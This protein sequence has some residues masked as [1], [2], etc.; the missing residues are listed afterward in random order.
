MSSIKETINTVKTNFAIFEEKDQ[1]IPLAAHNLVIDRTWTTRTSWFTNQNEIL[2][3]FFDTT[4]LSNLAPKILAAYNTLA[5]DLF[6]EK[7]TFINKPFIEGNHSLLNELYIHTLTVKNNSSLNARLFYS[8]IETAPTI[9]NYN[10]TPLTTGFLTS[11]SNLFVTANNDMFAASPSNARLTFC[12]LLNT[13]FQF[14]AYNSVTYNIEIAKTEK[15]LVSYVNVEE[16]KFPLNGPVVINNTVALNSPFA[17]QFHLVTPS[18]WP[19]FVA[20]SLWLTMLST[21]AIFHHYTGATRDVFL[22]FSCLVIG[23]ASWWRDV[24]RESTYEFK[25]TPIVRQGLLAGMALFIISE[26]FLFMGF[27]WAFFNSSLVPSA[28]IGGIW[29][30]AF[31]EPI[32]TWKLPLVNTLTLIMSGFTVTLAHRRLKYVPYHDTFTRY[33][34]IHNMLLWL[35]VTIALAL[36]FL[37]CQAFEYYYASF[38]L[39]DTAYGTTFYSLTGLHGM[40]VLVGTIFLSVCLWR[41]FNLHFTNWKQVGFKSA[42]WYW[43]FV[44]V[45]WIL[46]FFTVYIWGGAG[47]GRVL[48]QVNV[49]G[50]LESVVGM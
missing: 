37:S 29:P 12:Q 26:A 11:I 34:R 33:M 45:V 40:H 4:K 39:S 46:L 20:L 21:V 47:A 36:F 16:N 31:I 24:I 41:A 9:V 38:T 3:F 13:N 2:N 5:Y 44:D 15:L 8:Q 23:V 6:M 42:V 19:L 17:H 43:H 22:G 10:A 25:H 35:F 7:G 49:G 28:F 1:T 32:D 30:P 14:F 50:P 18:P 27:F 48:M